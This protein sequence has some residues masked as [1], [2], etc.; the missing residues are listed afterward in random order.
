MDRAIKRSLVNRD[1][2]MDRGLTPQ[3]HFYRQISK[4]DD[5]FE[6]LQSILEESFIADSPREIVGNVLAVNSVI[7]VSNEIANT[8]IY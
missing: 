4:V 6:G 1:V 8:Y 7:I 5:I 2:N 3:D